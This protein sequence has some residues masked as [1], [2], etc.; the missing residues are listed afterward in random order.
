MPD[1][2][3]YILAPFLLGF[4]LFAVYL[5]VSIILKDPARPFRMF[6]APSLDLGEEQNA[7][8]SVHPS[9]GSGQGSAEVPLDESGQGAGEDD[10]ETRGRGDAEENENND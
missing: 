4:G 10:A 3:F 1:P 9:T 2:L 6:K 7:E 5:V 8:R